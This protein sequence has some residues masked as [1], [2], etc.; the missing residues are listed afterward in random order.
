ME[1]GNNLVKFIIIK[2]LQKKRKKQTTRSKL[3]KLIKTDEVANV[4]GV[5]IGHSCRG[6][7]IITNGDDFCAGPSLSNRTFSHGSPGFGSDLLA[8]NRWII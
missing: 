6:F 3:D 7:S 2:I 8:A 1:F 4:L 5:N